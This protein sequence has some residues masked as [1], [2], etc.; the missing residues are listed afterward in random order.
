M[1]FGDLLCE[2]D[3]LKEKYEALEQ[4]NAE[5]EKKLAE[6]RVKDESGDS[7]EEKVDRYDLPSTLASQK[8]RLKAFLAKGEKH[9]T[10][11]YEDVE[12]VC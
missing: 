5:I 8:T 4:G 9:W 6:L 3:E 10:K 7:L 1:G 11:A 12:K 2:R